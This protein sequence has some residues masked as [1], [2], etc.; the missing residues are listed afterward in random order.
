M[1]NVLKAR[2]FVDEI[3]LNKDRIGFIS[4][5]EFGDLKMVRLISDPVIMINTNSNTKTYVAEQV[6]QLRFE[7]D[8]SSNMSSLEHDELTA[9]N[10][11]LNYL[12]HNL[13]FED[14]ANIS[15]LSHWDEDEHVL[16][17][18]FFINEDRVGEEYNLGQENQ[19]LL[20][21]LEDRIAA[22]ETIT[23]EIKETFNTLKYGTD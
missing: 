22:L 12:K 1:D 2:T 18:T 8:F 16:S 14:I 6:F 4:D 15:L 20:D 5:F 9:I 10:I 19:D 7:E 11:E 3:N 23:K 13:G 21:H 17:I